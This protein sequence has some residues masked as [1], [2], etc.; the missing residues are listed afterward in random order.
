MDYPKDD[1]DDGIGDD[2]AGDLGVRLKDDLHD[3]L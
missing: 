2:P 1:P 3:D